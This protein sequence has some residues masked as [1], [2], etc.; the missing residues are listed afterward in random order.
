MP[1]KYV[2]IDKYPSRHLLG[3]LDIIC[4]AASILESAWL[5]LF[6]MNHRASTLFLST[7]FW[8]LWITLILLSMNHPQSYELYVNFSLNICLWKNKLLTMDSSKFHPGIQ[9]IFIN[10][11]LISSLFC[12]MWTFQYNLLSKCNSRGPECCLFW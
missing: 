6:L 4:F 10:F 5:L 11:I 8:N 12:L 1:R 3:H 2:L 9:Y 7:L